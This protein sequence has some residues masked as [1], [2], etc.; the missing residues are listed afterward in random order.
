MIGRQLRDG[1]R[2]LLPSGTHSALLDPFDGLQEALACV[3]SL[4][5][6]VRFTRLLRFIFHDFDR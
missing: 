6:S 1:R 5:G 2:M 3:R 4:P